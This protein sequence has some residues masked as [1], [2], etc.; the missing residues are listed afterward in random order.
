MST[1]RPRRFL[2]ATVAA[3]V[4]IPAGFAHAAPPHGG[5]NGQSSSTGKSPTPRPNTAPA[6][7]FVPATNSHPQWSI[8]IGRGARWS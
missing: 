2:L 1:V 7:V 5:G 3:V 4:L 6:P 8:H